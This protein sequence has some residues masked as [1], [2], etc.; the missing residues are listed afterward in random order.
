[1]IAFLSVLDL[2]LQRGE[3]VLFQ[4]VSFELGAGQAIALTGANGSGKTSLLRAMAGLLQP[5]AGCIQFV[6]TAAILDPADARHLGIHLIGHHDGLKSARTTLEELVFQAEW[7]GGTRASALAAAERMDL[8]RLLDLDVRRL[9]AGQRRRLALARLVASP[10]PLWLLDEPM[11]PL[12]SDHRARFGALMAEHLAGGG[13]IVAAVHD[14][15]PVD[16]RPVRL[17]V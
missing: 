7:T 2:T 13:L 5:L 6:G 4:G 15:L 14:P 8:A 17:G 11:A 1:M 3:R 12:D 9:S 16:T 10:R